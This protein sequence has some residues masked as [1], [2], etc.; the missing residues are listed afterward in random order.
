MGIVLSQYPDMLSD[1]SKDPSR[2]LG[3]KV[4]LAQSAILFET[5]WVAVW[6]AAMVAGLVLLA[7]LCGIP[8]L[9]PAA[10]KPFALGLAAIAVLVALKPVLSLTLPS[11][12]AAL[13]R[14]E[15]KSGLKHRPVST[16]HDRLAET[17]PAPE[18]RVIWRAHQ[19]WVAKQLSALKSGPPQSGLP[20]RDPMA[21]RNALAVALGAALFLNWGNW[22]VRLA[23]AVSSRPV[24]AQAAG[25]DAWIAPPAYTMKPPLLLTSEA[26]KAQVKRGEEFVVP[27]GSQLIVRLNGADKP[28]LNFIRPGEN[29]GSEDPLLSRPIAETGKA[30]VFETKA[31]IERPVNIQVLSQDTV[32]AQWQVAVIP[33]AAPKAE[34]GAQITVTPTGAFSVPW[35]ASDDYGVA[36]LDAKF[37]LA[38]ED[39]PAQDGESQPIGLQIEPPAFPINMQKLNPRSANGKAFQDLT[40][41][42]WAGLMV[43]LQLTARDQAGQTG[44]S[45]PLKFQLPERSFRKLLA[46]AMVEQ[47][48]KLVQ[49][50]D[51]RIMIVRTLSALMAW[52]DGLIEKS[53]TY[54]NIRTVTRRLYNATT[55][56]ELLD[57]VDQLWE[58]AVLIEDGDLHNAL[59][60]L[61]ALR[62]ELQEALA[63]NAPPEK[64]AEL[65]S[66]L[67]EAMN[68]YLEAM[69][70]QM[71]RAMRNGEQ[72]SQQQIRPGEMVRSQDLKKMLD[73]IENLARQGARDAAQ[74]MLSQLENILRNLQ[75]GMARQMDPQRNSPM[76]RM[77][78]QLGDMMRRQQNL[79]DQTFRLPRGQPNGQQQ[80]G[81]QGDQ[82]GRRPGNSQQMGDLSDQQNALG[83]MLQRMLDQLGQQGMNAPQGL[84]HSREA[85]KGAGK[86][87]G[88]GERGTALGKQGEALEGLREGA[89]NM[90][91][92]LMQQGTG[93][94]GNYG[95]H[96]EAR[97]DDRDPLGRP[98]PTR[99][100]DFGPERNML[101]GEAAV[102]RAREILNLLRSRANNPNRPR[103]ELDYLNRLLRGLY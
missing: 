98:M 37:R 48:R 77:L 43:E 80:Q 67:R 88:E 46:R 25:L 61:E 63:N 28:V 99:S 86:A 55:E 1:M 57:V 54:L 47:R 93:N 53:G 52:P 13:R 92:Q 79:M 15:L 9:L 32:V 74:E 82:Q 68:R 36:G 87:L 64:I 12:E 45:K 56:K 6:P 5:A 81:Q 38:P 34:T 27:E 40:A 2:R 11:R 89:R 50:P 65:M 102:Q 39:G 8:A 29:A 73:M 19:D 72:M 59:K 31:V 58:I 94:E 62:K 100:T 51:D 84:G 44:V 14:I 24:V 101:P 91:Q 33:D 26:A 70:R 78:Q 103:I 35:K 4:F 41:H 76:A 20:H 85:M 18:S 49:T 7:V 97:G 75:P 17:N 3:R 71:Q 16:W 42:P 21:L 96:G 83:R 30:G 22:D 10:V 95:R 60:E 90:A 23:E 69:T 66:K